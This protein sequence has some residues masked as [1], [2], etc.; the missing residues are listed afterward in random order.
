MEKIGGKPS[1][2]TLVKKYTYWIDRTSFRSFSNS[3]QRRVTVHGHIFVALPSLPDHSDFILLADWWYFFAPEF[4]P[5]IVYCL[6]RQCKGIWFFT[7]N[8]WWYMRVQVN[9]KKNKLQTRHKIDKSERSLEII[10]RFSFSKRV[11]K[12]MYFAYHYSLTLAYSLIN[13][14][15]IDDESSLFHLISLDTK[16]N[17]KIMC[18]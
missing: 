6:E 7:R 17:A 8:A 10:L 16:I 9:K 14:K 13:Q 3:D 4:A 18:L 15:W 1:E 11:W 12:K 5:F 2:G